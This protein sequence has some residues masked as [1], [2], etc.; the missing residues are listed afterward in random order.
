MN[1][2]CVIQYDGTRYKG[3][4]RQKNTKETIQGTV[5]EALKKITG[6][7]IETIGAGRTDA[8]VHAKGQTFN[9][10]M[11][12]DGPLSSLQDQMNT[13]LPADM[14]IISMEKAED[15]FHSRFSAKGKIYAY[16]LR[17]GS[18]RNVFE[19]HYVW[20]MARPLNIEKMKKAAACLVGR[21]DFASFCAH[22]MKKSTVRTIERIEITDNP[23]KLTL[24][25]E[26]N[27]F[28]QGEVRIIT[29]TLVEV[30]E[31][32]KKPEDMESILKAK[33]RKQ[34]GFTAPARGLTLEK[35]IYEN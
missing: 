35:V 32:L 10:R 15:R 18:L 4:Q 31:G 9:M 17:T 34:A 13:L 12:W 16:R 8:G 23:E 20:Q 14:C 7:A 30:G 21:H 27:G 3:W 6:N 19:R 1:I 28:L 5:E 24:V 33:D 25:F 29:G 2:K 22:K 26:G 11:T